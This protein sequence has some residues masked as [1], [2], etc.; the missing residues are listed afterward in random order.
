MVDSGKFQSEDYA[1]AQQ[2][3]PQVSRETWEKLQVLVEILNKWQ[4]TINLVAPKTLPNVWIRHIA[5]SL[6]LFELTPQAQK[7]VDLGSG[8]GFPGLVIAVMLSQNHDS[9]H[10]IMHLVESDQRKCVFLR[11]AARLM[12]VNVRVHNGRIENIL[13]S[14][15]EP[16]DVVTAR[17]LSPLN[18]LISLAFPLLKTGIPALFPKGHDANRELTEAAKYWNIKSKLIPSKTDKSASIVMIESLLPS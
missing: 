11:E 13:S 3:F 5:D 6:Q 9:T 10:C 14:W 8:G 4:T 1:L 2:M 15:S 17:A 18:Q 16:A 12:N 7:W